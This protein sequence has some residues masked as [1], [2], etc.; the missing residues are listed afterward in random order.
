MNSIN[1]GNSIVESFSF[2]SIFVNIQMESYGIWDLL[3][4]IAVCAYTHTHRAAEE[5]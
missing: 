1:C 2:F 3:S 4:S 5:R